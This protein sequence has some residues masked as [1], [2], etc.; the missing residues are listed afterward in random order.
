M[1]VYVY[2]CMYVYIYIYIHIH[3][4]MYIHVTG[5][6]ISLSLHIYIYIY[7]YMYIYR[8]RERERDVICRGRFLFHAAP[9]ETLFLRAWPAC[10]RRIGDIYIY[11]YICTCIPL[12][13]CIHVDTFVPMHRCI[14]VIYRWPV[15]SAAAERGWVRLCFEV[16]S[17]HY[18]PGQ[19]VL[20]CGSQI[21]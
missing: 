20:D 3:I 12:S 7:I 15:V 19:T 8:E 17:I 9:L 1:Y 11:I 14:P 5:I 2:V 6:R 13:R 16:S 18:V 10:E 21:F 4:H